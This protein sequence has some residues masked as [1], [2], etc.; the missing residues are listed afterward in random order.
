MGMGGGEGILS[1]GRVRGHEGNEWRGG[2]TVRGEG[3]GT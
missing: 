3:D 2:D 1:E